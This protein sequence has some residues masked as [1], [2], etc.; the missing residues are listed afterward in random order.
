[1]KSFEF[2]VSSFKFAGRASGPAKVGCAL[3]TIKSFKDTAGGGGATFHDLWVSQK[4][5][6][7]WSEK[8]SVFG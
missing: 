2:R 8:F 3:R 4:P 6:S 7:D 1:L 5:M